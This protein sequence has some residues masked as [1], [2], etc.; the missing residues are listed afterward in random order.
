MTVRAAGPADARAIAQVHVAAWRTTY[1]RLVPAPFL[2]G[3]SVEARE[4]R[5]DA[6]LASPDPAKFALVAGDPVVGFASGGVDRDGDPRF[7]GEIYAI[8]LLAEHRGRGVGRALMTEAFRRLR[9]LGH[10][11]ALVWV[12]SANPACRFYETLG[13]RRVRTTPIDIGGR[14]LEMVAFGWDRLT[15]PAR[16]GTAAPRRSPGR[17]RGPR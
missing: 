10:R 1:H 9:E 13:A 4:K 6:I 14:E 5:W 3:L 8:Y 2:D 12:L 7:T 11:A 15:S 17:S 16:P